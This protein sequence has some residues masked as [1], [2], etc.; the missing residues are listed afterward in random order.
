MTTIKVLDAMMG[1]GKTTRLI[2][3]I[4]KLPKLAKII[5]ITPLISECHRVAGTLPISIDDN[6]PQMMDE[7]EY[8]YL[9]NHPLNNRRFRH[10]TTKQSAKG[11]KLDD[12]KDLVKGGCNIVSTHSLFNDLTKEI[13]DLIILHGYIL[14]LDEVLTMYEEYEDVDKRSLHTFF[15]NDWIYLASDKITLQWNNDVSYKDVPV[16]EGFAKLCNANR[17]LLVDNNIVVIEFPYNT[18]KSFK[19]VYVATYMFEGSQ[20]YPYLRSYGANISIE[21][22]GLRP[23]AY[24]SLIK[25]NTEKKI[26]FIGEPSTSL[27]KSFFLKRGPNEVLAANLHNFLQNK[28]K[29]NKTNRIWTTFKQYKNVIGGNTYKNQWLAC[30]TKATNE[31]RSASSVAYMLNL[32]PNPMIVKV[33]AYK[34]AS[35]N[36]ELYALSEMVQFIWRSRIRDNQPINLYVPSSR[37][38]NLLIRWLDDEFEDKQTVTQI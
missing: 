32:Y 7:E 28:C 29:T 30:N 17:L 11:T 8:I 16:L 27:S 5:Y 18:I 15:E 21:K 13:N 25:L 19:E 14:V 37:M 36:Q 3:M 12:F 34:D 20:M 9:D 31:Y 6:T 26:N 10:P 2:E 23:S 4:S 24:K 38:R 33:L 22:F 35:L 1:S